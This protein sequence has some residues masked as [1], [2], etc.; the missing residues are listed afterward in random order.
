MNRTEIY[1]KYHDAFIKGL[2]QHANL[3]M[4]IGSQTAESPMWF[5][6]VGVREKAGQVS[7]FFQSSQ[8]ADN[9]FHVPIDKED[10]W[11]FIDANRETYEYFRLAKYKH[12]QANAPTIYRELEAMS[13]LPPPEFTEVTAPVVDTPTPEPEPQLPPTK[14][15]DYQRNVTFL[16][17][18]GKRLHV[19]IEITDGRLS[20]T[21]RCQG[22]FGQMY[23]SIVPDNSFQSELVE[24]WERWHNNTTHAGT[25]EQE[26]ALKH[27]GYTAFKEQMQALRKQAEQLVEMSNM[28]IFEYAKMKGLLKETDEPNKF[29]YPTYL[30]DELRTLKTNWDKKKIEGYTIKDLLDMRYDYSI[31]CAWLRKLKLYE[32]TAHGIPYRYGSGWL[33]RE[34]PVNITSQLDDVCDKVEQ[35]EKHKPAYKPA[36]TP[37]GDTRIY[38]LLNSMAAHVW[39]DVN[40]CMLSTAPWGAGKG[41]EANVWKYKVHVMFDKVGEA[42]G[43]I[44]QQTFDYYGSIA[45]YESGSKMDA[46]ALSFAFRSYIMDAQFA[47]MD[48]DD[49]C[50][51]LGYEKPSQAIKAHKGCMASRQ[52]LEEVGFTEDLMRDVLN[53]LDNENI[54]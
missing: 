46:D 4:T 13:P 48:I 53:E 40:E 7:A 9:F 10:A 27:E 24:L 54:C 52:Q 2:T 19:E 37:V 32:V 50:N 8:L 1:A 31:Q 26:A 47:Y 11:A 22:S 38:L 41:M 12:F 14:T 6:F 5:Q 33:K 30:K 39:Y 29:T 35:L 16:D 34:L 44:G 43:S 28:N 42:S 23:D 21:G 51:E 18:D 25:P 3:Y 49:F 17:K 20:M 45:E 36:V 15:P